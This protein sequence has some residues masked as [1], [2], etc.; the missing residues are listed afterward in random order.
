MKRP[1][2]ESQ[3]VFESAKRRERP[4]KTPMS[5][6]ASFSPAVMGRFSQKTALMPGKA[7][8]RRRWHLDLHGIRRIGTKET[9]FTYELPDGAPVGDEKLLA[10][11]A[12]LRIPPAWR[13]VRIA[14]GEAA[15]LQAVGVDKKGRVQY[16]YHDRD[17]KSTRLNSSHVALS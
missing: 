17:R 1:S 16:R 8:V 9:G 15:P 5:Q 11:I 6:A 10:R 4:A 7:G 3:G 12:R 13:D 14:R 2:S